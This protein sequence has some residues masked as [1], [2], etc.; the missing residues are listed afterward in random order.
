MEGSRF[1]MKKFILALLFVAAST[2]NYAQGTLQFAA[3][4]TL[5]EPLPR[6]PVPHHGQG[7]FALDGN[8]FRYRVE[9]IP[10]GLD[11]WQSSQILLGGPNGP[12]LFNFPLT[13]CMTPLGTN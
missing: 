13:G 5:I 11:A 1:V 4:L 3:N 9:V 10:Y 2:N 12:V 6:F 7:I 8:K